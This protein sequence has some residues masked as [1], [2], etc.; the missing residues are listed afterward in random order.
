MQEGGEPTFSASPAYVRMMTEL[1]Q[2][3]QEARQGQPAMLPYASPFV[4]PA[5]AGEKP[6][7]QPTWDFWRELERNVRPPELEKAPW[8][9]MELEVLQNTQPPGVMPPRAPG[10]RP[11]DYLKWRFGSEEFFPKTVPETGAEAAEQP[12]PQAPLVEALKTEQPQPEA[13]QA[14]GLKLPEGTAP[15]APVPRGPVS[16][17]EQFFQLARA[18]LEAGAYL[19]AAEAFRKAGVLNPA[20]RWDAAY[21]EAFAR[22]LLKD[23]HQAAYYLKVVTVERPDWLRKD[24]RASEVVNRPADWQ[25]TEQ[26]LAEILE[27]TPNA[28]HHAFAMA[29]LKL[30]A[31]RPAEADKYLKVAEKNSEYVEVVQILRRKFA[32]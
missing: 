13:Q 3:P 28:P 22:L 6:G 27:H 16:A 30:F 11:L 19:P 20:L 21:G 9:T 12:P 17:D 31:G 7:G 8:E 14:P 32:L 2:Q 10:I 5:K 18:D 24:F 4:P 23:Y 29:C 25:A 1:A 26:A 15:L